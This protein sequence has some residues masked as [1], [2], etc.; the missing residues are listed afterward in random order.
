MILMSCMRL[1]S[2]YA[3]FPSSVLIH[4][5]LTL[6]LYKY[7]AATF[8]HLKVVIQFCFCYTPKG[9]GHSN[10][11]RAGWGPAC[12]RFHFLSTGRK[13]ER[14]MQRS[15]VSLRG[16]QREEETEREEYTRKTPQTRRLRRGK[17]T[18]KKL[19]VTFNKTKDF[20]WS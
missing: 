10:R 5:T 9:E 17:Q 16:R 15:N 4:A 13:A 18:E 7:Y 14:G 6:G 12:D 2:Q 1:T 19:N 20:G 8:D 3:I 11:S